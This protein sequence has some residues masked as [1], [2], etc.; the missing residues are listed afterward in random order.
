MPN[1]KLFTTAD[2]L[3]ALAA[4]LDQSWGPD[5]A[6]LVR[7]ASAE[8]DALRSER[9]T[10]ATLRDDAL[11]MYDHERRKRVDAE[12]YAADYLVALRER[13]AEVERL[14]PLVADGGVVERARAA[15][16]KAI[17]ALDS[18]P[19]GSFLRDTLYD[20]VTSIMLEARTAL[21][22]DSAQASAG[23]AGSAKGNPAGCAPVSADAEP[24]PP[25]QPAEAKAP[26]AGQAAEV[27]DGHRVGYIAAQPC[28]CGA[29]P[30]KPCQAT[31]GHRLGPHSVKP[32]ADCGTKSRPR[33]TCPH[34]GKALC[35]QCAAVA[36][37]ASPELMQLAQP[38]AIEPWPVA[39]ECGC[40]ADYV[41]EFHR[42]PAKVEPLHAE[43][44]AEERGGADDNLRQWGDCVCRQPGCEQCDGE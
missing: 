7:G 29:G 13:S 1:A 23:S 33:S 21:A 41:C 37:P 43:P 10:L 36:S 2:K 9:D 30:D 20:H 4:S 8:L 19:P 27:R 5:D 34:C 39:D 11:E 22:K 32:C 24:F 6:A 40:V 3:L 26:L 44:K 31:A 17:S 18:V 38:A 16:E 12:Q 14:T 35:R 15:V 28:A 42:L 25:A